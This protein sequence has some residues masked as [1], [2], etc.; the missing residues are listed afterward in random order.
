MQPQPYLPNDT[1]PIGAP[2]GMVS[3]SHA[4]EKGVP[5]GEKTV[6]RLVQ[7][8]RLRG[9]TMLRDIEHFRAGRPIGAE[10]EDVI[11]GDLV[12]AHLTDNA[13]QS[14]PVMDTELRPSLRSQIRHGTPLVVLV[15][16]GIGADRVA[17]D[18][19]IAG[20]LVIGASTRWG[21]V[22][23]DPAPLDQDTCS[24]IADNALKSLLGAGRGPADG[25]WELTVATRGNP[26]PSRGLLVD[27][28][29][30]VGGPQRCCGTAVEWERIY[31][32]LSD[33]AAALH[34]HGPRRRLELTAQCHLTAALATGY[35]FRRAC[36]WTICVADRSGRACE[37]GDE[38]E[39][40][41]FSTPRLDHGD[42]G[43]DRLFVEIA[44]TGQPIDRA[45]EAVIARTGLP[46]ARLL[47]EDN[48]GQ[49]L[50]PEEMAPA[51]AAVARMLKTQ[52]HNL[53]VHR[54]NLFVAAPAAFAVLL[55]AELN[56]LGAEI[57]VH[58]HDTDDYVQTLTID[59]R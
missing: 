36:G 27:A 58:E 49:T 12:I 54:V 41:R 8:L 47:I 50:A 2:R 11:S 43:D 26:M 37:Q 4:D 20:R 42:A 19:R 21:G 59:A 15:P 30:I 3:Y 35:L 17:V 44:I 29:G 16:H 13:L 18:E 24:T 32:G 9:V 52:R 23:P 31:R 38:I 46:R 14:E 6:D 53:G 28:T 55:G 56:S 33:L 5:D 34:A 22:F 25:C 1:A 45:V 7:E 40:E 57:A 39:F 51:A 10:M 48:S